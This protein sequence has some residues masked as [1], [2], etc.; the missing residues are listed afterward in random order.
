MTVASPSYSHLAS[1]DPLQQDLS[2]L[3]QLP[4]QPIFQSKQAQQQQRRCGSRTNMVVRGS[5]VIVLVDGQL[6]MMSLSGLKNRSSRAS[7]SQQQQQPRAY[8][9]RIHG[10]PSAA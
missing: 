2:W 1:P 9:V 3:S 7:T 6:R 4:A 8:K 10:I 5:D